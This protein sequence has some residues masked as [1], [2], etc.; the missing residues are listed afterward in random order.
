[1]SAH[2]VEHLRIDALRRAPQRQLAQCGEIARHEEILRCPFGSVGEIDFPFLHAL[3]Q[4][5][6]RQVHQLDIVGAVE[7]RVRNRF[8]H[9]HMGDLRHHIV[10]AFQ[11]LHVQGG[12]NIDAIVE[13]F[14]DIEI[15]LGM[16]AARRIGMRQLIDQNQLRLSL[17]DGV[18]IH[19]C[20]NAAL[21]R[22]AFLR[23][24]IEPLG[25]HIGFDAAMRFHHAD[26]DVVRLHLAAARL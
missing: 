17:Q 16:A 24:D 5:F 1:M 12:I 20:Q 11:V 8:A 3:Q 22:N 6:R 9:A 19:L 25:Q 2:I 23:D 15:T 10:Q 26:D 7:N 18:Q 14:L 21:I 13:N 4:V